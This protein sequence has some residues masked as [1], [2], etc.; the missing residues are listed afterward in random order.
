M[1]DDE[2]KRAIAEIHRFDMRE[3]SHAGAPTKRPPENYRGVPIPNQDKN[4]T[5]EPAL[6]S[7]RV[8]KTGIGRREQELIPIDIFFVSLLRLLDLKLYKYMSLFP[9]FEIVS[10]ILSPLG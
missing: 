8:F 7:S 2:E 6:V 4:S 10:A 3:Q 9:C 5:E 1:L